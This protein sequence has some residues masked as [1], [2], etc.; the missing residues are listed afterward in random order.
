M[1]ERVDFIGS[2]Q[3]IEEQLGDRFVRAH[4]AYLINPEHIQ[5]LDLK[6]NEVRM[7]NGEVCLVSRSMKGKLLA[8]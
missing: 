8:L 3:E 2:L 6:H 4:R 1:T 7:K 5:E